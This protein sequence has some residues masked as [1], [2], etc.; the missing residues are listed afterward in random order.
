M[1]E[2]AEGALE[3]CGWCGKAI[4]ED[5][6]VYGCGVKVQTPA[7]L[8]GRAGQLIKVMMPRTEQL[9]LAIVPTDDSEARGEGWDALVMV[10]GRKC[11]KA[12]SSAFAA[13]KSGLRVVRNGAI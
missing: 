4:A 3:T 12:L 13:E 9:F 5:S 11:K 8:Q 6:P 2:A 1:I 7:N 10:C